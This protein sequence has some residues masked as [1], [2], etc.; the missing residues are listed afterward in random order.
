[1]V[2][3]EISTLMDS[4]EAYSSSCSRVHKLPSS[5][6]VAAPSDASRR[7]EIVPF[8]DRELVLDIMPVV[9]AEAKPIP[10]TL[11]KGRN[12]AVTMAIIDRQNNSIRSVAFILEFPFHLDEAAILN[13]IPYH[14]STELILAVARHLL[15]VVLFSGN[16]VQVMKRDCRHFA[17]SAKPSLIDGNHQ[18]KIIMMIL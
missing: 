5:V 13:F 7:V 17:R 18:H 10:P 16:R 3:K 9:K 6:V 2:E 1:M 14:Y 8:G 11:I 4:S 12:G 15:D